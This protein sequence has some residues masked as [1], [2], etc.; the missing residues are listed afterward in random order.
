MSEP[1]S[2]HFTID[3]HTFHVAISGDGVPVLM[4]P[5][6]M[7]THRQWSLMR[8]HLDL[9]MKLIMPDPLG[10]GRSDKPQD[11]DAYTIDSQITHMLGLLD[12]LNIDKAHVIGAEYGGSTALGLGGIAPE[13]VLS[14]IAIEALFTDDEAPFWMRRMHKDLSDSLKGWLTFRALKRRKVAEDM[15]ETALRD[16]WYVLSKEDR[17]LHSDAYLDPDADRVG[18]SLQL[19]AAGGDVR[20]VLQVTTTPVLYLQGEYS[21]ALE[22]L[23]GG[24]EFLKTRLNT[25]VVTVAEGAHDLHIQQPQKI[26]Q[27]ALDFWNKETA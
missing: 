3:D 8:P 10:S 15:A 27:I 16:A 4:L 13:R 20:P 19:G 17:R 26:A 12:A 9:H 25:E 6:V 2:E 22:D 14:V 24:V 5:P 1:Q 7:M 11:E 23:E 21:N 18:W